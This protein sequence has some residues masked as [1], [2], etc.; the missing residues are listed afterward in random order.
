MIVVVGE[1][2]EQAR[3]A[4]RRGAVAW[5][6]DEAGRDVQFCGASDDG[7]TYQLFSRFGTGAV[8]LSS[9]RSWVYAEIELSKSSFVADIAT[10]KK[11][12]S[13]LSTVKGVPLAPSAL[14]FQ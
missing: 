12:P 4:A 7:W 6:E 14:V 1:E 8:L 10:K 3:R 9:F 2:T 13:P 5:G 11:G